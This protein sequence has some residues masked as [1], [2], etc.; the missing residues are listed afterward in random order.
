M[1]LANHLFVSFNVQS[2][3][4]DGFSGAMW[5]G[6]YPSG[7]ARLCCSK[8]Q[9]HSLSGSKQPRFIFQSCWSIRG[10]LEPLLH[11]LSFGPRMIDQPLSQIVLVIMAGERRILGG[12]HVS[13]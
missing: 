1:L 3:H 8:K 5:S 7:W 10:Q 9:L 11:D 6:L 2:F 4:S 12:S 13:T